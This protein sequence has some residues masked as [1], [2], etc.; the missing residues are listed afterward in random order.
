[1]ATYKISDIL[2]TLLDMRKDGFEY[3]ELSEIEPDEDEG[4]DALASLNIAAVIAAHSFEEDYVDAVKLP[5]GYFHL[6]E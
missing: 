6:P 4:A 5:E 2:K 1:M 3:V